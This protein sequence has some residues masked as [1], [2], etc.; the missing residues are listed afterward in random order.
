M[1]LKGASPIPVI[2]GTLLAAALIAIGIGISAP[3]GE[4]SKLMYPANLWCVSNFIEQQPTEKLPDG[5]PRQDKLLDGKEEWIVREQVTADSA[6]EAQKKAQKNGGGL[7]EPSDAKAM[8]EKLSAGD[9]AFFTSH[10]NAGA[11]V[12]G[13]CWGTGSTS[14]MTG[15]WLSDAIREDCFGIKPNEIAGNYEV[16]RTLKVTVTPYSPNMPGNTCD[17]VTGGP[18]VTADGGAFKV[19]NGRIRYV[20]GSSVEDYVFAQPTT[21]NIIPWNQRDQYAVVL[22]GFNNN[23]PI[24]IRDHYKSGLHANQN[25][26]DLFA[27]CTEYYHLPTGS[28]TVKIVDLTKPITQ[29]SSHDDT[30]VKKIAGA[31]TACPETPPKK[32]PSDGADYQAQLAHEFEKQ[33]ALNSLGQSFDEF[34]GTLP[35]TS[36]N[37]AAV[38]KSQVGFKS[39]NGDCTKYDGCAQWCAYFATWVYRQAG[40]QIPQIGSSRE[41]LNW[42][43]SNGHSVFRDPARAGEGDIVVW[44]RGSNTGHIGIVYS[45]DPSSR[46]M[47]VVEGNTS[48][49]QV[50]M[51][52]YS[53][54]K[55]TN[56][57]NGLIGFGRW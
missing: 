37:I 53:Y 16:A 10:F 30:K 4:Q 23:V 55:V 36:N 57:L 32:G 19:V 20:K 1:K 12:A 46:T 31:N 38:A 3:T 51:Y 11:T 9:K 50:K 28:Q 25:Y 49:D 56:N 48:H 40:Y 2:A 17:S 22:P 39:S 33:I 44:A 35:A 47:Y 15:R 8:R 24:K 54:E 14:A 26:L 52:K 27:P 6:D 21:D 45:N 42:F 13:P 41:T 34:S 7:F 18:A 29:A 5:R 43:K